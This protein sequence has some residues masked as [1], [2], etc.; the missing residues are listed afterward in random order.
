MESRHGDFLMG[1]N[2]AARNPAGFAPYNT[3]LRMR[4]FYGGQKG[5][6]YMCF[7]ETNRIGKR[8][9]CVGCIR[10]AGSWEFGIYFFNPVRLE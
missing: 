8:R 9:I 3:A 1:D 2:G 10:V 6:E 7:C 5:R 4:A